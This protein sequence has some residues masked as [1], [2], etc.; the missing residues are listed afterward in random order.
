MLE[1]PAN[2]PKAHSANT[3][4]TTLK[5]TANKPSLAVL[6]LSPLGIEFAASAELLDPAIADIGDVDTFWPVDSY[7]RGDVALAVASAVGPQLGHN[8]GR[9]GSAGESVGATRRRE[10]QRARPK[11]RPLA[12]AG[13][14]YWGQP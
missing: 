6:K 4:A 5:L 13:Q 2:V 10:G 12:S 8:N 11:R 3:I 14:L 7:P 9:H 1:A